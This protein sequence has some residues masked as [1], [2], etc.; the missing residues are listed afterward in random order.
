MYLKTEIQLFILQFS[1]ILLC[2]SPY[3]TRER[4]LDLEIWKEGLDEEQIKLQRD[5][6]ARAFEVFVAVIQSI[7]S[8]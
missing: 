1:R 5:E 8:T 6:W 3:I 7:R 2:F 4:T